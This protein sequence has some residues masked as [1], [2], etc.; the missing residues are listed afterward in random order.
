AFN[1]MRT[2]LKGGIVEQLLLSRLS[3]G[4]VLLGKLQAAMVQFVLYVSVLAPLLATSYLLRG[5]DLPTIV[6]SLLF[7]F[8]IC[9]AATAFAVSSA[10]QAV[11]PALQPIANLAV[12]FGLGVGTISLISFVVSGAYSASLGYL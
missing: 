4:S 8:V 7:A 3:P 12:A 10:A 6:I 1:S 11:V 9:V 2:E 5:V